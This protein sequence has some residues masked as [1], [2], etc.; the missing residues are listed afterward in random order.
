MGYRCRMAA[1]P[2][3]ILSAVLMWSCQ[4]VPGRSD[5]N[6]ST[7]SQASA[8]AN[9]DD[10]L[11][12]SDDSQDEDT[13]GRAGGDAISGAA[14][15]TD[16]GCALCHGDGG[17]DGIDPR[18]LS[19]G[20]DRLDEVL[21]DPASDHTGGVFTEL[22]DD[23]LTDLAAFLGDEAAPGDGDDVASGPGDLHPVPL[24]PS[25]TMHGEGFADPLVN[26]AACH[27]SDLSG[28][29]FAPS[30]TSCHAA[31]WEGVGGPPPTHT[32][33]KGPN[34]ILHRPG[35]ADPAADCS[36]CHGANLEGS[37]SR[38]SCTSCHAAL[39]EG[40]DGPPLTHTE[41]K[42]PNGILH[43]PGFADPTANCSACHGSGLEGSGSRSSCTSC[44]G[45]L[46]PGAGVPSNHV[47]AFGKPAAMHR[48][49]QFDADANCAACHGDGLTGVGAV[50]N[51]Y[52]C[53]GSLWSGGGPPPTHTQVLTTGDVTG[54]HAEG[55]YDPAANCGPC[56]QAD[57]MG[58]YRVPA[59]YSCHGQ[60]WTGGGAPPSHSELLAGGTISGLHAPGRTEP[61]A[62]CAGCHRSDLAGTSLTPACWRCHGSLWDPPP[63]HPPDHVVVRGSPPVVHR[64]GLTDPASN[65]T[66]CHGADLT[67]TAL[68]SNCYACHGALWSGGG[69]PPTHTQVLTTGEV[70]GVHPSG[71]YD[72]AANCASCHQADL[73]GRHHVP[74]CYSCHGRLWTGGG[75]PP[76]HSELLTN[77]P[78]SG[79]HA[80]GRDDPYVN[81]ASCHRSDLTGTGLIPT[82]YLCHGSL[83]DAPPD[84][85]PDHVVIQGYPPAVHRAGLADPTSNCTACHGAD[86]TGT[87][88]IP[89]C[90]TC[91]GPLWTGQGTAARPWGSA[92]ISGQAGTF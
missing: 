19:I 46:W 38:P 68:T 61:Q 85:P 21:R 11:N 63:D 81:C 66:A 15:Y 3:C 33:P 43:R 27:G 80:L 22:T 92:G 42:G 78:I 48:E 5:K 31:L 30:C 56:H 62:N 88:L 44:H 7:S 79:L 47:L 4:A 14:L 16:R 89:G 36:A 58:R 73:M 28:T 34:G 64:S 1:G 40:V 91:H 82:C 29:A 83:W 86:L 77:G 25:E 6:G 10:N 17:A 55:R 74:T 70:T 50:P 72:P 24:G 54:V 60:L 26:C 18:I 2:L 12:R 76:S 41:P 9:E 65:C 84:Y 59:C 90:H 39:W 51:C 49:G 45:Q 71:R 87:P 8:N 57:L 35:F 32:E 75:A 20:I 69:L 13:A 23:D 67:G 52:A 53:H 37:A